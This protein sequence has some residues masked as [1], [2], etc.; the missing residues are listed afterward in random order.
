MITE[1]IV[2]GGVQAGG[3]P[4]ASTGGR[5]SPATDTWIA[6][7]TNG[8]PWGRTAHTAVW[9]GNEMIVWGG[10][11]IASA[12]FPIFIALDSGGHY[13]P[14][15]DQWTPTSTNN[16]PVARWDHTAV[17]TGH[18]MIVWG[19]ESSTTNFNTGARY[20]PGLR[21]P[22]APLPTNGAPQPRAGHTAVWDS[23]QMLVW[24]GAG[25]G[26]TYFADGA[27]YV[28]MQNQWY[29]MTTNGAPAPRTGHRAVWTGSEMIVSD[30]EN[31]GTPLDTVHAYTPPRS[32]FLYLKP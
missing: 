28:P 11:V 21:N 29:T 24:G 10:L 25:S 15:S 20:A 26:S 8:A 1:M 13:D 3:D 23:T 32:T 16:P 4:W 27:R 17:W 7:S 6:T 9:T 12:Q 5:Y 14:V 31:H 2:W 19:G 22:W 30:G 18:E